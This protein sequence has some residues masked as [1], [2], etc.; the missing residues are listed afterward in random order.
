MKLKTKLKIR[1]ALKAQRT[2]FHHPLVSFTVHG[3]EVTMY[4]FF[5]VGW[6]AI[7]AAMKDK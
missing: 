5:R 7:D 4:E 2:L 6:K 3:K 1:Y